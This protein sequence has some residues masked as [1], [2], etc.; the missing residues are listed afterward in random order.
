V[1]Y[2]KVEA[3]VPFV[4]TRCCIKKAPEGALKY[5]QAY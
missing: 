1:C 4:T 3:Y 2:E 5:F